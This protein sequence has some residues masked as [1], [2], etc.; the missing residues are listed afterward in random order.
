MKK[1]R[2]EIPITLSDSFLIFIPVDNSN[3]EDDNDCEGDV[4]QCVSGSTVTQAV[5]TNGCEVFFFFFFHWE[6][7]VSM[8]IFFLFALS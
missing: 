6:C 2:E 4:A 1:I 3:D 8:T 7:V 5:D